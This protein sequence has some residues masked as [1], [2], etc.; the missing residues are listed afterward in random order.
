MV[1]R[2]WWSFSLIMVMFLL[3]VIKIDHDRCNEDADIVDDYIDV[4]D[5]DSASI[6][7][8]SK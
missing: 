4:A 3:V 1:G 6:V 5:N 2:L 8:P 7:D